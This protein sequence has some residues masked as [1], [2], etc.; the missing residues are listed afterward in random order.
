MACVCTEGEGGVQATA[1]KGKGVKNRQIF[2]YALY[3]WPPTDIH[4]MLF[5]TYIFAVLYLPLAQRL[6][7][8]TRLVEEDHRA[9]KANDV[10]HKVWYSL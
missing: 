5:L 2:A 9:D 8:H 7:H 10:Q 6:V 3:G 1:Y 4:A